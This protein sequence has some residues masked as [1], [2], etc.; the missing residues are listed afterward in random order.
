[1]NYK[2]FRQTYKS[3][4]KKYPDIDTLFCYL[5]NDSIITETITHYVKRGSKWIETEKTTGHI[6]ALYYFNVID[7]VYFFRNLGGYEK[8]EKSY[9]KYG[10]IP[11]TINSINP[12]RD[13]KTV[14]TYIF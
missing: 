8:I 10:L 6:P 1:M 7:S 2:E 11:T 13:E 4:L 3:S 5:E 9:T 14:R 12:S